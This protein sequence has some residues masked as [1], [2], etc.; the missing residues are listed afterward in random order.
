MGTAAAS[1]SPA[2]GARPVTRSLRAAV[3]TSVGICSCEAPG[4]AAGQVAGA[5]RRR[6][7][8]RLGISERVWARASS[9]IIDQSVG[10]LAPEGRVCWGLAS[11]GGYGGVSGQ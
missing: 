5:R 9:P 10:G 11:T 2:A 7:V 8:R 1:S 6:A 3:E 4:Q